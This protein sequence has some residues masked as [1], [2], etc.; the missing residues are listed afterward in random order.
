MMDKKRI[1]FFL[2]ICLILTANY[3]KF[4]AGGYHEN[5]TPSNDNNKNDQA[6]IQKLKNDL[7]TARRIHDNNKL[8]DA[9]FKIAEEYKKSA[10][11][12][13][14]ISYYNQ[15][16]KTAESLKL[17]G[18]EKEKN[19]QLNERILSAYENLSSL[20]LYNNN[21]NSMLDASLKAY[22]LLKDKSQ[23]ERF[24]NTVKM[25]GFAH[26]LLGNY[27]SSLQY[28]Q[29]GMQYT[30]K[31]SNSLKADYFRGMGF[32]HR[33]LGNH[34]KSIY[35]FEECLHVSQ[36]TKFPMIHISATNEIGN[37][38]FLQNNFQK[39]REYHERALKL[40][41]EAKDTFAINYTTND[42]A[43]DYTA[44]GNYYKAISF[45]K[46]AIKLEDIIKD[47]RGKSIGYQNLGSC[48]LR[49][50]DYENAKYYLSKSYDLAEQYQFKSEMNAA[51]NWLAEL[52]FE[53]EDF[54]KAAIYFRKYAQLRDSLLNND[55][56]KQIAEMETKY[57]SDRKNREN[58]LLKK[59]A[60]LKKLELDDQINFRN[61]LIFLS[62][63]IT[64]FLIILWNRY[65]LKV[66]S[67][68]IIAAQKNE[69]EKLNRELSDL[70]FTKDKFF[71]I[72]AHDLRNPFNSIIG[73]SSM[74]IG[75]FDEMTKDEK[76][77]S[78]NEINKSSLKTYHLLENLLFWAKSQT[79]ALKV[80]KQNVDLKKVAEENI[81]LVSETAKSKN[82]SIKNLIR[83]DCRVFADEFMISTI[84]R[85]LLSNAIKFTNEAGWIEISGERVESTIKL[86]VKDN[87]A[88]IP[89]DK[90]E[91]IF[92]LDS[93][94]SREGKGSG[95]GL[96][97]CKE[98][99]EMNGGSIEAKSEP[100]VGSE[101]IVSL[102]SL[103]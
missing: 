41:E 62:L 18:T 43:N 85:N 69:L 100:G 24:C 10:V 40:A 56:L 99:A 84:L 103:S 22:S 8:S 29:E 47:N 68:K 65:R 33:N 25:I 88:G 52:Y 89:P 4:A 92:T 44:L 11:T 75:N 79:G 45:Y 81:K 12:D 13:S 7:Q 74:L 2:S 26:F 94:K 63:L 76:L 17:T 54:E 57:D 72:I 77:E 59:D 14:A 27:E 80:E 46:K 71:S 38:Y 93:G 55:N 86:F 31:I 87:G 20:Y 49:I 98:F 91:S 53:Q 16:I 48:Y 39:S 82:I 102:K 95:L 32:V 23:I 90:L 67:S 78:I 58:E 19:I 15:Y 3:S 21:H 35:Y 42:L 61:Y 30:D 36:I 66:R 37:V 28:F 60:R 50:K 6:T 9:T 83:D 34:E 51:Q 97:L 70:N 64:G 101:F 96:V 1:L 73:F 5:S